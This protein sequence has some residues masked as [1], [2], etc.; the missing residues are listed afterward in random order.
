MY[1]L[2]MCAWG[3]VVLGG[4]LWLVAGEFN[5]IIPPIWKRFRRYRRFSMGAMLETMT[6]LGVAM[7]LLRWAAI[8]AETAF[9]VACG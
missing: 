4:A 5:Q 6:I 8:E 2:G 1:M 3:V 7:G 9:I